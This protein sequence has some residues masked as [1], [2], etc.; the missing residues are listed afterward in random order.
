M[1]S[2]K[3]YNGMRVLKDERAPWIKIQIAE[4]AVDYYK[5][6]VT[7]EHRMQIKEEIWPRRV[8][9]EDSQRC[10]SETQPHLIKKVYIKR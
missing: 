10:P 2:K 8:L 7:A 1:A 4:F 5:R 9:E 3:A 6:M